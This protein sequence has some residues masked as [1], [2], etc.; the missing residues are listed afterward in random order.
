MEYVEFTRHKRLGKIVDIEGHDN[1]GASGNCRRDNMS[2][3]RIGT[4]GNL[5]LKLFPIRDSGIR[6]CR[7]HLLCQ[8]FDIFP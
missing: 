5:M 2:V 6:Q 3:I 1:V 8:A 7:I 4:L